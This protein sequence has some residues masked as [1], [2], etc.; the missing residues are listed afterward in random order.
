MPQPAGRF[1]DAAMLETKAVQRRIHPPDDHGGS[2]V[3]I[4]C[5]GP[6]GVEFDRREQ[7]F[8]PFAFDRPFPVLRIE[9]LWQSAPAAITDERPLFLVGSRAGFSFEML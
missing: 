7:F 3:C 4:K 5:G 9:D 1:K 6:G 8:Q 2:V